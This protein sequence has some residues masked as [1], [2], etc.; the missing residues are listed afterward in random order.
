MEIN[1]AAVTTDQ[2]QKEYELMASAFSKRQDYVA[3][4][5]YSAFDTDNRF[6]YYS[7]L[8]AS[9]PHA[10][11]SL[12]KLAL[13]L[14]KGLRFSSPTKS[15][16]K[17]FTAWSDHVNFFEQAYTL[18][19]LLPMNGT[20][21]G[22]TTGTASELRLQ[23]L[24]MPT[25]TLVPPGQKL[26]E[27]DNGTVLTGPIDRVIINESDDKNRVVLKASQVVY[28]SFNAHLKKQPD[29]MNRNTFGIYGTSLFESIELSIRNLLTIDSGY[30]S[31]VRKYGQ[32]RY[33]YDFKMLY[34]A[35]IQKGMSP[36]K[37]QE[38]VDAFMEKHKYLRANEDIAGVGIDV[39]ELDAGGSL[40]VMAFKKSLETN[41]Q[42][43][44]FQSP[45]TMGDSR[46]S[47]YAAGYVAEEDRMLVLEGLQ[48]I[49]RDILQQVVDKRLLLIG[50]QPGTVSIELEQLSTPALTLG[51]MLELYNTSAINKTTFDRVLSER[52]G[53]S[54]LE[55]AGK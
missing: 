30:V 44:L 53:I 47:T 5:R 25:V 10:S 6:T 33:V 21:A 9:T 43:G 20:Y 49:V 28:G 42:I 50:K 32:G 12:M 15:L 39:K 4:T 36:Q 29:T 1:A 13:S 34:D 46:G 11:T 52:F 22:I 27:G 38:F 14:V 19:S 35:V 41:I 48:R 7:Q 45:L 17:D 8:A 16:T 51:D 37:A 18:A 23:H 2:F 26:G 3:A 55:E 31:F 54:V 24:L 40:D